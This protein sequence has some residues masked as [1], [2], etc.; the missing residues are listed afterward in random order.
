MKLLVYFLLQ[1][2]TCVGYNYERKH[3]AVK[4]C[5]VKIENMFII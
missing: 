4:N 5:F 2:K 1:L 3:I